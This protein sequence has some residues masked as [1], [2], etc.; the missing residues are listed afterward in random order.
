MAAR[1]HSSPGMSHVWVRRAR[2]GVVET[3]EAAAAVAAALQENVAAAAAAAA[4]AEEA[5]EESG[6]ASHELHMHTV[7]R[8]AGLLLGSGEE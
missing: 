4:V 1:P 6:R 2:I 7:T 8:S 3:E 5:P